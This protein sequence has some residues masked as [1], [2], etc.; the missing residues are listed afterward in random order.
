MSAN[1]L[2]KSQTDD[3]VGRFTKVRAVICK[4]CPACIVARKSPQSVVGRLL[5]HPVH[6]DNCP[7]WQAYRQVYED[8]QES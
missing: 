2:E 7:M 1:E 4:H 3:S 5:H 8:Q 6:A